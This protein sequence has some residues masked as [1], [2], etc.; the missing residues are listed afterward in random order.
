MIR[1]MIWMLYGAALLAS[2]GCGGGL[3]E[4]GLVKVTG[5]VTLDGQPL[6]N[7]RVS[8]EGEDKRS[9]QGV[10]DSGGNYVLMYDDA[11]AGATPGQKIV[12]ITQA[13]TSGEA[14]PDAPTTGEGAVAEPLPERYNRK[15]EL[16]ADVAPDKRQFDFQLKTKP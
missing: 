6:A 13:Q 3:D 7:A 8:F 5:K 16:T 11:H 14:D 15:S 1:R 10:T 4:L 12:R 9:A 2:A